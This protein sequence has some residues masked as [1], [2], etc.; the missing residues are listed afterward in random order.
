M[1]DTEHLQLDGEEEEDDYYNDGDDVPS[2]PRGINPSSQTKCS[3]KIW[4]TIVAWLRRLLESCA[5]VA[6]RRTQGDGDDDAQV[7]LMEDFD[8]TTQMGHP[9]NHGYTQIPNGGGGGGRDGVEDQE[10]LQEIMQD[11][12]Q[13]ND[14]ALQRA[15]EQAASDKE[16]KQD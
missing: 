15:F 16:D 1:S 12:V 3:T 13:G 2:W 8:A 9:S 11:F 5:A 7:C 6:E 14:G 4:R 10:T